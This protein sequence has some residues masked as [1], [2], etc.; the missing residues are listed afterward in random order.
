M[1]VKRRFRLRF[2]IKIKQIKKSQL[3]L[4]SK[5]D[6]EPELNMIKIKIQ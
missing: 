6:P 1:T 3:V 2:T 4:E 5:S